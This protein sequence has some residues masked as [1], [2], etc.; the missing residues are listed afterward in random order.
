VTRTD[1]LCRLL[2]WSGALRA[3]AALAARRPGRHLVILAYH[4]VLNSPAEALPLDEDLVSCTA[5]EFEREMAFV[6]RTFD[7]VSFRN[8]EE[9][10]EALRRP[11]IVTFDDGYRDNHD[12][13]LPILRR[14]GVKATF[15]VTTGYIGAE[16]L[17]WWDETALRLRAAGPRDWAWEREGWPRGAPE[18]LAWAKTLPDARRRAVLDEIR[19]QLGPLPAGAGRGVMM[20]WDEVRDLA[21]NGMEIGSHTVSHPVLANVRDAVE[22]QRELTE[23]RGRIE[24]ETGREAVALSYPVGRSSTATETVVRAARQAG[25]RHACLYEHGVNPRRGFDPFRLRRI[26]AEVG[27][28]F[29]RFRAKVLFPTWIR[30]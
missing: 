18:F 12:V 7:V 17:P 14:H 16:T 21:A 25:Y 8:L 1:L 19:H 9:G 11:L 29:R 23:S 10:M 4:R 27:A 20:A 24:R 2:A 6:A 28:D 15:F 30:Y 5:A 26:K 3:R 22:L 13:A